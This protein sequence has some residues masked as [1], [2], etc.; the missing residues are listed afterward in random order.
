MQNALGVITEVHKEW[1]KTSGRF[2]APLI[3]EYRLE[4]ADYAIMTIGSMTG[5]GRDAVDA[6]R[7]AAKRGMAYIHVFSPCPTGWRFPPDKLID[8]GRKAVETNIAPLWEY[9]AEAGSI[10]FTHPVEDPL[11]VKAY[12][13]L[14]GKYHHLDE[15]QVA[16]IQRKT[17]ERIERL[18]KF[19]REEGKE[20]MLDMA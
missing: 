19:T 5:A 10:D 18:K 11:P 16:H 1:E 2:Y 9:E 3:E 6:A 12:L 7:E 8:V 15:E 17:D 13:S 4:D 14:I 20:V